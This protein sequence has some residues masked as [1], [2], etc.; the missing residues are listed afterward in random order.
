MVG[1]ETREKLIKV[2]AVLNKHGVDYLVVGGAAVNFYGHRRPSGGVIAHPELTIDLDFWYNPTI[3]N[4]YKLIEALADLDVDTTELK[5][6][7][8]NPK[9]TYLKIPHDTFHTDF[10][11]VIPGLSSFRDSKKNA[12]K[13][14]INGTEIPF[15]SYNDLIQSKLALNRK[16]DKSDIDELDRLN[17]SKRKKGKGIR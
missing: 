3:E 12:E 17:K 7:V 1:G 16:I 4:F 14:N 2:C 9:S 8:F 10:L 5:L 6:I 13:A 15:I 11:P